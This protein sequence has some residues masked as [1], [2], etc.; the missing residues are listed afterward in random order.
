MVN[1]RRKV[2]K[3]D[4]SPAEMASVLY[5]LDVQHAHFYFFVILT[6]SIAALARMVSVGL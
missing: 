1:K 3:V 2:E 5:G 6:T 4:W